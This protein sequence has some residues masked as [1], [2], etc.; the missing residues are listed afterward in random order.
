MLL[1]Y[2]KH[3]KPELQMDI[4]KEISQLVDISLVLHGGSA[5]SDQELSDSVQ[6]GIC[7]INISSDIST[8]TSKK[9]AKF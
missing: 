2:P 9:L 8:H 5:N 6:L 4:L 1:P 3:I 7:K